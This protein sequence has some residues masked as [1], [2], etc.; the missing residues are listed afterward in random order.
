MIENFGAHGEPLNLSN[1][2]NM[3]HLHLLPTNPFVEDCGN[4]PFADSSLP[5]PTVL[6]DEFTN[7]PVIPRESDVYCKEW[8]EKHRKDRQKLCVPPPVIDFFIMNYF[9]GTM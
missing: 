5:F 2:E 4:N 1:I 7:I 6:E 9:E 3:C 8:V